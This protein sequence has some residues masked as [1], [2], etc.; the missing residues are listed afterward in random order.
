M[1]NQPTNSRDELAAAQPSFLDISDPTHIATQCLSYVLNCH[2]LPWP[3][4][5]PNGAANVHS[6]VL[7]GWRLGG[8][9]GKRFDAA[10]TTRKFTKSN[11]YFCMH[12]PMSDKTVT[13]CWTNT[14]VRNWF[15]LCH[16]KVAHENVL[17]P[18][19]RFW[20]KLFDCSAFIYHVVTIGRPSTASSVTST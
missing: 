5:K 7:G 10:I 1:A 12:V 4:L 2:L 3:E 19:L 15:A 16:L 9:W 14:D 18:F 20:S 11:I 13:D 17:Y 8:S 6:P